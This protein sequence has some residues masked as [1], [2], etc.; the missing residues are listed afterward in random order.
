MWKLWNQPAANLVQALLVLR[1]IRLGSAHADNPEPAANAIRLVILAGRTL[2]AARVLAARHAVRE[3]AAAPRA[4]RWVP[5]LCGTALRRWACCAIVRWR[6]VATSSP[7]SRW[8][9]QQRWR[10]LAS[11]STMAATEAKQHAGRYAQH[12]DLNPPFDVNL[13]LSGAALAKKATCATSCQ[14][15]REIPPPPTAA[16]RAL[17][18]SN[19]I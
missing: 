12:N 5:C 3:R 4:V 9:G 8:R 7:T 2:R 13:K 11:S 19:D 15:A 17:A 18:V 14:Q 1:I 6:Q 16:A 10:I